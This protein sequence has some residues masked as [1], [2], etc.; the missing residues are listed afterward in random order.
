MTIIN[1]SGVDIDIEG[2]IGEAYKV[3]EDGQVTFGEIVRL[4]GVLAGRV[5]QFS[6]LSGQGKQQVVL[7][8]IE[9][10]LMK[11]LND[12]LKTLPED[13]QESF[14]V[15]ITSAAQFAQETLPAVLDVAVQ[16]SKGLLILKK[17]EVQRNCW[18]ALRA[19]LIRIGCRSGLLP[20][21]LQSTSPSNII[22]PEVKDKVQEELKEPIEENIDTEEAI[23]GV[24]SKEEAKIQPANE[25]VKQ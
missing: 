14:R 8:T 21:P 4:G 3:L 25:V 9:I 7:K 20:G 5:S 16:A 13:K 17:P 15:R 22:V 6:K 1:L 23:K 2:L 18:N 19:I 12:K 24:Q 11:V 10:A